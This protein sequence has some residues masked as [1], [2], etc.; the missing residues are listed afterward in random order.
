[1]SKPLFPI[2]QAEAYLRQAHYDLERQENVLRWPHCD[3]VTELRVDSIEYQTHDKLIVSQ[4]VTV[5]HFSDAI[6]AVDAAW[7]AHLNKWAT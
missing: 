7:A 1:M 5:E 2:A 6:A 3:G 4:L